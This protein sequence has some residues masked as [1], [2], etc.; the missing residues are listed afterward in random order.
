[1]RAD[2]PKQTTAPF[3][4]AYAFCEKYVK[5]QSVFALYNAI[6]LTFQYI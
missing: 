2:M 4:L 1:M 5:K 3:A 6:L